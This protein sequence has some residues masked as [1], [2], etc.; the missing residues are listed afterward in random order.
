MRGERWRDGGREGKRRGDGGREVIVCGDTKREAAKRW[1]RR[2]DIDEESGGD[3][4][5][6]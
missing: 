6:E 4:G 1:G 5:R 3:V 2:R